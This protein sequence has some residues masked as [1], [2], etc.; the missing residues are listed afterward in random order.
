MAYSSF[1]FRGFRFLSSPFLNYERFILL[2]SRL[3]ISRDSSSKPVRKVHIGTLLLISRNGIQLSFLPG[4]PLPF[5]SI[6]NSEIF[7][8]LVI[9]QPAELDFPCLFEFTILP[10]EIV[11]PAS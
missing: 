4:I 1:S 8:K 9:C 3:R 10:I 5:L 2:P 11:P 6:L 7:M